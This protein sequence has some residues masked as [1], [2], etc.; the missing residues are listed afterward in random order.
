MTFL[1][2]AKTSHTDKPFPS[3]NAAPSF[4][5][6]AMPTPHLKSGPKSCIEKDGLC[7]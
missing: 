2:R 1:L 3:S 4:C 6:A 7:N 5:G